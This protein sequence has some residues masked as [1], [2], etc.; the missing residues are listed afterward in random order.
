MS[1]AVDVHIAAEVGVGQ[2]RRTFL[3][4]HSSI[5]GRKPGV[6]DRAGVYLQ[7][8]GHGFFILCA[9]LRGDER[10]SAGAHVGAAVG[11]ELADML[12]SG[13]GQRE[14][15]M[16]GVASVDINRTEARSAVGIEK[17]AV[18]VDRTPCEACRL[19]GGIFGRKG[20][21]FAVGGRIIGLHRETERLGGIEP[22]A[23]GQ[24]DAPVH[25][26]VLVI[27]R[28]TGI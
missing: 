15:V 8:V 4:L 22:L 14:A 7:I 20:A 12:H 2:E 23:G 17:Y 28:R 11:H 1:D 16:L 24:I 3:H 21:V 27:S 25:I 19:F 10:S 18:L 26:E 6:V 9:A 5:G 13:P